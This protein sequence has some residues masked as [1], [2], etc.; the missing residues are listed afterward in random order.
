MKAIVCTKYGPPEVLQFK[1]VNKPSPENKEL[2]I[3]VYTV[4][5]G[6]EDLMQRKGKPYFGRIFVG[7]TKPGKPI[8]GTE[9]AG[10]IEEVGKDV[11]LFKKSDR[12]F[13]VTGFGFGCYASY[14][15]MPESGLLSIKPPNITNE[16]AAPICGALAAWNLLK[17]IANIQSGQKVLIY[18]ASGSIGLAAVQIAKRF[19]VEV[20][21]VCSSSNVEMV[22][23]LGADNVIDNASEDFAK[24]GLTYDVILDVSGNPLSFRFKNS[25]TKRGFYLTTYPTISILFQTLW[26]SFFNGK[27]VVFSATAFKQVSERLTF[28]KELIKLF[29][30]GKLKTIIDQSFQLEQMVEAHRY[31]ERGLERGNVVVTI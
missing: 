13:G 22:K 10:E 17:V 27:K 20:T 15:C 26:T 18:G 28:L 31:I 4:F 2:L 14:M 12:V 21:G 8:L 3:R 11:K 5:V 25:L 23:S 9:F 7:F 30:E 19:G 24:N 6:I 16:E 1:E 29:K